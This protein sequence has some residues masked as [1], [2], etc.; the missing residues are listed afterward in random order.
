MRPEPLA[1]FQNVLLNVGCR[2][3][4]GTLNHPVAGDATAV[5]RLGTGS[6]ST[7]FLNPFASYLPIRRRYRMANRQHMMGYRRASE[8][9]TFGQPETVTRRPATVSLAV[10]DERWYSV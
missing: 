2:Y 8:G 9:Q 7:Q 1:E 4:R 3:R 6:R 10:D 5:K